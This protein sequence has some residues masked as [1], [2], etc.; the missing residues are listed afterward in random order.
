MKWLLYCGGIVA[1]VLS[2]A[3]F[4]LAKSA[5]HEIEAMVGF[6]IGTVCLVGGAILGRIDRSVVAF[7]GPSLTAVCPACT[8]EVRG[9]TLQTS[10]S[11]PR[12]HRR[13]TVKDGKLEAV[14]VESAP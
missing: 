6:L 1:L 4:G 10:I 5:I 11:C 14:H 7:L 9:F 3:I 2:A 13:F 12:C 8:A